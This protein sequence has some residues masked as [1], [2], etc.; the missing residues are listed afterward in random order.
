MSE[1][2]HLPT[3]YIAENGERVSEPAYR[4][5]APHFFDDTFW[6]EDDVIVST[7]EP[8]LHMEPLN[9][10]AGERMEAFVQSLPADS[11][12]ISVGEMMEAAM[13]LRPREG[14]PE[15]SNEAFQGA[16]LKLAAQLKA[17]RRGG[18]PVVPNTQ[19]VRP[20][21]S[22]GA[23]PLANARFADAAQ[24][25]IQRKIQYQGELPQSR[26]KKPP[27]AGNIPV[28]VKG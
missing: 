24:A 7:L 28:G 25:N 8:T 13:M 3:E 19:S 26:V 10:A 15:L 1:F 4:L 23:P 12:G 5:K 21:A 11:E 6:S 20:A 16:V 18:D 9:Q 2:S 27:Q 17:K 14:E 22:K